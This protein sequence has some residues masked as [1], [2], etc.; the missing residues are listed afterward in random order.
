MLY[1]E[2]KTASGFLEV[3]DH[4]DGTNFDSIGYPWRHYNSPLPP[5]LGTP[6]GGTAPATWVTL[7]AYKAGDQVVHAATKYVCKTANSDAV[8]TVAKWDTYTPL[9]SPGLIQGGA[10]RVTATTPGT[11]TAH[12]SQVESA[13]GDMTVGMTITHVGAGDDSS[14]VGILL[15]VNNAGDPGYFVVYGAATSST[16]PY[17]F[18]F[19]ETGATLLDSNIGGYPQTWA[20]NGASPGQ[21]TQNTPVRLVATVEGA[22]L[23]IYLN[24]VL[25]GQILGTIVHST[26]KKAG[27]VGYDGAGIFDMSV[28]SLSGAALSIG[29][30]GRILAASAGNLY[31]GAA[32]DT[33]QLVGTDFIP[34]GVIRAQ[35]A[36]GKVYLTDGVS[37]HYR[38]Y[39]PTTR[40]TIPW[41]PTAGAL[42]VGIS[43]PSLG[44]TIIKLYRGRIVLSGIED[45]PQNWFMSAAGDPLDW[46]Y[47]AAPT[48]VIAVAGNNSLAGLV[49]DRVTCLIPYNDDLMV[50]G[51]DHTL[52]LMRGDP[53]DGGKIDNLSQQVGIVSPDAYALDPQGNIYFFG[54]GVLWRLVPSKLPEPISRGRL[55]KTF[56]AIDFSL[57]TMRLLWDDILHG[58]HIFVTLNSTGT[59]THYWWD[60]RTDGFWADNYPDAH[61]PTAV[62]LFD[63]DT[64]NDRAILLGGRDGYVRKINPATKTDDGTTILSRVKFGP[65]TPGSVHRNARI[66]RIITVL[67]S[68]SDPV[69]LRV[70]S[71]Q[72]PEEVVAATTPAWSMLVSPIARY[73]V[74]RIGG[75]SALIELKNDSFSAVWVTGHVYAVGDQVVASDGNPYV[76]L[77]A[78][79]STTAGSH[80]T[81]PGNTTDWVLSSFR[82][83]A[84][85]SVSVVNEVTG[86]TRHGRI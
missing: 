30:S 14:F 43:D 9:A 17:I 6:A 52:W 79:T 50:M 40:T 81:P 61:G 80:D 29:N 38:V 68:T 8:F 63:A 25:V 44:A 73:S 3:F 47:G 13:T 20:P 1:Q 85:E 26:Q 84:V 58:L 62:L 36:F 82:S 39:D 67:E 2:P 51:C 56:G 5:L 37:A 64:L 24:G 22:N 15:R 42:P 23:R 41:I 77:T 31:S 4:P 21:T 35:T 72:S 74:P 71:A 48:A 7:T 54:D 69:S 76:S 33:W 65:L 32:L 55:D 45:D 53:A 27:F 28:F 70:F 19:D 60:A 10:Y 75:N 18:V 16:S 83:W 12:V 66:S 49:G 57:N 78:H 34:S 86:Q 46:D 59:S 11:P